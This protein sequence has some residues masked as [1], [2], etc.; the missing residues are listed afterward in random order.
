MSSVECQLPTFGELTDEQISAINSNSF[1]VQ[2]KKNETILKQN[3]PVSHLVYVKSGL[4][5]VF[6]ES[7]GGKIHIL[8][9]LPSNN[10]IGLLSVFSGQ[11][12][13]YSV[14]SIENCEIVFTNIVT[15]KNV[16]KENGSFALHLMKLISDY[17]LLIFDKL[18]NV[19]QKQIPGRIAETLIFFSQEIYKNDT[20]ELPL[21]RQEL[22]E[23]VVTTKENISRTLSE[24]KND[25]LIDF[26][27][28]KIII[29]SRDNIE[30]LSRIG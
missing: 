13:N 2:Y 26:D 25:R 11:L 8:K 10:F 19:S 12:N 20:F 27:G 5:K 7:T 4:V 28:R 1:V 21:S 6:K 23:L 16:I 14:A 18:I 30:F 22:A 24:F 9:I 15:V 3:I 29:K 17:G